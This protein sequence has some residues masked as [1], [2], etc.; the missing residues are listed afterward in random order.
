MVQ[1]NDAGGRTEGSIA[2]HT[3][4]SPLPAPPCGALPRNSGL[5]RSWVALGPA[6]V[7]LYPTTPRGT[8]TDAVASVD[9]FLAGSARPHNLRGYENLERGARSNAAR[10]QGH[11]E[12]VQTDPFGM[13]HPK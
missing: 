1:E 10:Q 3:F 12:M 9:D 11:D 6:H 2:H 7:R 4:Q 13:G 5:V 8:T